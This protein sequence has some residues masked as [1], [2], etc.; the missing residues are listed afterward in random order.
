MMTVDLNIKLQLSEDVA[1]KARE[2]GLFTGEK[3]GELIEAE[4]RRQ[5]REVWERLE[6]KLAGIQVD[7]REEYG[8]LSDDEVQTMIDQWIGEAD[9]TPDQHGS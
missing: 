1:R 9:A 8:N 7:F 4:V 6:A 2:A 3:I 5:R